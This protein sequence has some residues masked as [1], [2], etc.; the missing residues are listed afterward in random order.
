MDNLSAHNAPAVHRWLLRH[1]RFQFHFTP[2]YASWLNLVERFFG[3][4]TEKALKPDRIPAS[5]NFARRSWPMSR[6]I[7]RTGRPFG[8]PRPPTR[9]STR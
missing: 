8:G 6:R 9:S 1:P 4:L 2:T 5:L 3:L 7:T